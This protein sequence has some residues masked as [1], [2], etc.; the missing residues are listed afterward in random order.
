VIS[1]DDLLNAK[2]NASSAEILAALFWMGL[3]AWQQPFIH[4][5][6]ADLGGQ[7]AQWRF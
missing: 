7:G 6:G 3:H 4:Q 5:D 2:L 1:A